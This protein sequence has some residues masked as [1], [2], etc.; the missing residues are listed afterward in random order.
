MKTAVKEVDPT[1]AY[2]IDD[3][4]L[5]LARLQN[6]IRSTSEKMLMLSEQL[7]A[8]H[9]K[10]TDTSSRHYVMMA[11]L[12][13]RFAGM[14]Q[15]SC[16]RPGSL[17]RSLRMCRR[18][19]EQDREDKER[20]KIKQAKLEQRAARKEEQQILESRTPGYQIF[21][22]ADQFEDASLARFSMIEQPLEDVD[23]VYGDE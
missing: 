15:H 23:E 6:E 12:A 4:A 1:N 19:A 9:R 10:G 2:K 8:K 20:E 16:Q 18:I 14:V 7:H 22:T 21:V 17:D 3:F 5:E 11:N 13:K